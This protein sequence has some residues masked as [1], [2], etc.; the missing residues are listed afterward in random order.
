[1]V[2][3]PAV[4]RIGAE[5]V[6]VDP[7]WE[8]VGSVCQVGEVLGY[9]ASAVRGEGQDLPRILQALAGETHVHLALAGDVLEATSVDDAHVGKSSPSRARRAIRGPGTEWLVITASAPDTP[10]TVFKASTL[11]PR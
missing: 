5:E 9:G 3:D 11:R 7:A 4:E 8:G 10:S 2:E 1:M 6:G